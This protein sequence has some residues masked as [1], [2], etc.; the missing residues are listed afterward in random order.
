SEP[1]YLQSY[2]NYWNEDYNNNYPEKN[3]TV[4]ALSSIGKTVCLTRFIQPLEP[5][6]M[7][8][9][10]FDISQ[11]QCARYVSLIPFSDCN[12]LYDHIWLTTEEMLNLMTGTVID[13]SIALTCFFLA[14][15]MDAWLLLGYGIPH[16]TTA[17]V[18]VR[19]HD[20]NIETT[21][22]IYDTSTAIKYNVTERYCP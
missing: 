18:L 3:F 4:Y 14:L 20:S 2:L 12:K 15:N 11:E 7:N 1:P 6:Q 5:P 22:Y 21:H 13:H 9:I 10:D 19:E 16:G 8:S 17:Y